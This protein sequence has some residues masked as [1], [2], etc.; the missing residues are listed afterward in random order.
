[1]GEHVDLLAD[2][3]IIIGHTLHKYFLS[4]AM[5]Q[6]AEGVT[7]AGAMANLVSVTIGNIIGGS[8]F[9]ALVYWAVYLRRLDQD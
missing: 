3:L 4:I 9:V 2:S 5:L 6:V 8:I 1:M 7:F